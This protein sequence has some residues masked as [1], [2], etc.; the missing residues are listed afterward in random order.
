MKAKKTFLYMLMFSAIGL[1]TSCL[2]E[3]KD[4]E[5]NSGEETTV[6][7]GQLVL[8]LSAS[9][10]FA[11]QTTRAL[12]EANY[13]NTNNYTVQLLNAN[14]GSVLFEC[15]GSEVATNLP[16]TLEIGSYEVKAFYGTESAA[17]RNDFRVEGSSSFQIQANDTKTV[18]VA[19]LPTCGRV[20]VNFADDMATYYS[21]Y[22]VSFT[23]TTAL[24]SNSFAWAKA[25]NDPWYVAVGTAGEDIT[26]TINVTAKEEYAHVDANGVKQTT[27]TAT[28]SFKLQRNAGY[29]LNVKPQYTPTTEGGIKVVVTIDESTNDRPITI[30]VPLTWI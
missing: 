1:T 28:G 26:Y 14:S 27:G 24:G 8:N 30:E 17:S 23:G 4:L 19:C 13:R 29:K 2:S 22:N 16:K 20:K 6:K 11:P 10:D 7:K 18:N 15:L 21:D 12:N 25:D 3:V 9:T 5:P